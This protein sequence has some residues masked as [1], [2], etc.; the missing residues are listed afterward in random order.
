MSQLHLAQLLLAASSAAS[1][2]QAAGLGCERTLPFT[3][4]WCTA[5]CW[6]LRPS[7]E[8]RWCSATPPAPILV[9]LAEAR[10]PPGPEDSEKEVALKFMKS[11][12]LTEAW[13]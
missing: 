3:A 13:C 4:R 2:P 5:S 8:R 12:A 9:W 11:G 1:S 7:Y 6:P 10:S